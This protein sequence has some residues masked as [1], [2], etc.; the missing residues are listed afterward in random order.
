MPRQPRFYYP[1][2][3]LHLI[4]RGN[5][6]APVFADAD[7]R[8][9]YLHFLEYAAREHGVA[10]HAYVLMD[11][12]VHLL[13]SPDHLMAVPRMMQSLG[14]R[15]V[16]RFNFLHERSGTL[17]E[18]RYKAALVDSETYLFTCH[19]YIE[20][21]PVR[22][23]MV[24]SPRDYRWSSYRANAYGAHDSIVTPHSMFL[25]LAPC[26]EERHNL[27]RRLFGEP[28]AEDAMQAIRDATQFEWMLG[29]DSFKRRMGKLTGRRAER[30]AKGR[31]KSGS[32]PTTPS[33]LREKSP[34]LLF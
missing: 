12:H 26:G 17:W 11:N 24:A 6:R 32:A 29:S 16:G 5:D 28:I 13:V 34:L 10:I 30:L 31:R 14:R 23:G 21:N 7:D 22:A 19:R 9:F 27:Y 4:Q 3:V 18:G 33:E 20:L 8:R 2:A 25:D 15:Y 1:N